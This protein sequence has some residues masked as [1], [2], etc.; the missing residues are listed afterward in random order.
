MPRDYDVLQRPFIF[1]T[2]TDRGPLAVCE[3]EGFVHIAAGETAV[4]IPID[5]FDALAREW[6]KY[7][8]LDAR[9]PDC[10]GRGIVETGNNDLP[11]QCPAGDDVKIN[12]A[13]RGLVKGSVLKAER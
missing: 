11:C 12:V 13:G 2:T 5:A 6:C 4:P 7:R 3:V 9:C 10:D 1:R 8:V